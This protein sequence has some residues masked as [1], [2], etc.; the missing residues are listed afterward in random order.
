MS[1]QDRTANERFKSRSSDL[2]PW[3]IVAAVAIHAAAFVLARPFDVE[4]LGATEAT[5]MSL[6]IPPIELPE[7]PADIP[8]PAAPVVGEVD[9]DQTVTI[10]RTDFD[11]FVAPVGPPPA[12]G[13]GEGRVRFIPYDTPP[14]LR[15][16]DRVSRILEREYPSRLRDAGVTGTV[17]L[18]LYVEADGR[19]TDAEVRESSGNEALD[20]AA[21]RVGRQMRFRPALNRDRP[22]AVW[23]RQPITFRVR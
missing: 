2:A 23:V 11:D 8:R 7:P 3:C 15:D 22:T 16:R 12:A 17:E 6:V 1:D 13:A 5:E 14:V 9:L 18:W 20:A 4:P 21:V 10:P 19:V